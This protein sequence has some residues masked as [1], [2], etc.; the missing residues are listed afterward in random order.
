MSTLP[1]VF[2]VTYCVEACQCSPQNTFNR[3]TN[4][5]DLLVEFDVLGVG[6][7]MT[8]QLR[9]LWFTRRL[10]NPRASLS[11]STQS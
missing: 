3:F 6:M 10:S 1:S 8:L 9:N 7:G 2:L 4:T 11:Y 5:I